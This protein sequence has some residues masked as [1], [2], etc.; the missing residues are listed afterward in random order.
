MPKITFINKQKTVMIAEGST[1][2]DAARSAGI[3]IESPCNALGSC[4]KCKVKIPNPEHLG[5]LKIVESKHSVSAAELADGIV[6]ACQTIPSADIEVIIKDYKE[7][8]SSLRILTEGNSFAYEQLPY[9]TKRPKLNST[10]VYGGDTL[11]GVEEGNTLELLYAIALD[12]GT[13]TIV[14]ALIDLRTGIQIASN[15]ILNPQAAYAQDVLSRIHFAS[16]PEGL[17][18]LYRSF[19]DALNAMIGDLVVQNKINASNIY[20]IVFSGNTTMIHLATGVNPYSLGQYPYTPQI[21]G[22]NHISAE[23]IGVSISPFGLIYLPPIIS[24]YVGADITS[25]ILV[26]RLDE[27]K[28]TVLFIDIGTNGEMA[29]V[30][31]GKLAV[32]STAA[33]P[34]FEG[35][36][37]SCGM[38]ASKGSIESFNVDSKGIFSFEVI[39]G[40]DPAGICGSGLLDI[41]G[42]LVRTGVI[43]PSG[44]FVL[45]DSG[46]YSDFLKESF[47]EKNGKKVFFLSP[48]VYLAQK[49]IRQIQL[50]KSA[51]RSGIEML[52]SYF[53]LSSDTIDAVEI[54]GSFGYHLNEASLINLGLLP[55]A[56]IG[57]VK[58]TGNTSLSGAKA[59]LLNVGFREKMKSLVKKIETVELAKESEF[60][61]MFIKYMG[62]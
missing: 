41:A 18:T 26:S 45:P 25:G 27:I 48:D 35:M 16:N 59:F 17:N 10:E 15:S 30:K 2:L 37:I 6:L 28:G 21:Y 24:A 43:G 51:I 31:N 23:S 22:G 54:A 14:A 36:N 60:E 47:K 52:L 9:I 42:E 40:G 49:D 11:I 62:F 55:Q 53:N 13:T 32:T 33:G 19:I 46:T 44:R 58:F 3:E 4:G 12:I 34:A 8:N 20:E 50:A 39:G 56:F 61:K 5:H 38:R 1:I 57:K 29:L 7:E